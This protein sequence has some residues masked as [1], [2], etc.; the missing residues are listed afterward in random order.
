[1]ARYPRNYINTPFFHI[2]VQG[3]NKAYIFNNHN[4]IIH[5]INLINKLKFKFNINI[6]AYCIMNNHAHILL[7]TK[8]IKNLSNFMKILNTSYGIYYNKKNNRVGYV[9]RNRFKSEGIYNEKHLY[10]CINYIYN[11]P[12]KA[13]IC[14]SPDVYPYSNYRKINKVFDQYASFIDT[15]EDKIIICKSTINDFIKNN[16]IDLSILKENK[17]KL[18]ELLIILREKCNISFKAIAFELNFSKSYLWKI[19]NNSKI[20]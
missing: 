17:S 10:N 13:G 4:D 19:Y 9:F 7:E 3:I 15:D 6:I 20:K 14:S 16:S 12:V 2:M 11:N 5:Y 1:M 8:D 18:K